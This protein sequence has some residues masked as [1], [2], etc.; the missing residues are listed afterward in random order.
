MHHQQQENITECTVVEC[1]VCVLCGGV[2][3]VSNICT[4]QNGDANNLPSVVWDSAYQ[5]DK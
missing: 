4:V 2:W 1:E 3:K 5:N